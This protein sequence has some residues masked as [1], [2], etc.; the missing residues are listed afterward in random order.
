MS[1]TFENVPD[2]FD[3]FSSYNL[4]FYVYVLSF[5][6]AARNDIRFQE[7]LTVLESKLD[8]G[9]VVVERPNPKLA[10]FHFCKK[11]APSQLATA[12]YHEILRNIGGMP[13]D[14][15]TQAGAGRRFFV[16]K[17]N[18][19]AAGEVKSLCMD[20][21]TPIRSGKKTFPALRIHARRAFFGNIAPSLVKFLL[22][23]GGP[24]CL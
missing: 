4:F 3:R 16:L 23:P 5:Y 18:L 9:M 11:G 19:C 20:H 14:D 2:G 8:G 7:A 13:A 17:Y 6:E 10:S 12:R 15:C 22:A 21:K 24:H 1:I